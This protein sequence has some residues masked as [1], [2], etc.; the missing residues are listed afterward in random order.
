VSEVQ[1]AWDEAIGL[2]AR[3]QRSQEVKKILLALSAVVAIGV[4]VP[5]AVAGNESGNKLSCFSGDNPN[6]TCSFNGTVATLDTVDSDDNPYNNYSGV[7]LQNSNLDGKLLAEITKLSFRYGGDMATAGSPR[8]S[9]PINIGSGTTEFYAFVSAY[10]CNDGSGLVNVM[11]DATCTI[12][13]GSESFPNWAT[14]VAAHPTW[15]VGPNL[16]FVIADDPGEWTVSDVQLGKGSARP[17][18]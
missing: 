4:A 7:Y 1:A 2:I 17:A 16:P 6:V 3:K 18:K 14:L 13:A 12:Y 11:N 9:L 10:Y 8:F 5:V 15:K